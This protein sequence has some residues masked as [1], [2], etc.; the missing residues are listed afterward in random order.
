M[1]WFD[2]LSVFFCPRI[3]DQRP[4]PVVLEF[5]AGS[6][7]V[8]QR[9]IRQA[10]HPMLRGGSSGPKVGLFLLNGQA[11]IALGVI[12]GQCSVDMVL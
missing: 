10:G 5:D 1:P 7:P 11:A 12:N 3:R 6:T 8:H 4:G 2:Y 9:G